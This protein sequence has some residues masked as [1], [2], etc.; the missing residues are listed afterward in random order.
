MQGGLGR[1]GLGRAGSRGMAARQNRGGPI[2]I[3]QGHATPTPPQSPGTTL[4]GR[5]G[6]PEFSLLSAH[7]HRLLWLNSFSKV[8]SKCLPR[9]SWTREGQQD[10]SWQ[11]GPRDASRSMNIQSS[12]SRT[13]TLTHMCTCAPARPQ[14]GKAAA[15]R[16]C[17]SWGGGSVGGGRASGVSG[18]AWIHLDTPSSPCVQPATRAAG[19]K[20]GRGLARSLWCSRRGPEEAGPRG[21]PSA[22]RQA[23]AQRAPAL[24]IYPGCF[25]LLLHPA[26]GSLRTPPSAIAGTGEVDKPGCHMLH[27][28]DCSLWP[29]GMG[30]AAL[31]REPVGIGQSAPRPASWG[32]GREVIASSR[33]GPEHINA[34]LTQG[35]GTEATEGEGRSA[36]AG[37]PGER[38]RRWKQWA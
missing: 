31:N 8:N 30:F 15:S 27:H 18:G 34:S 24:C 25:W 2:L 19:R 33:F 1:Q 4:R 28:P 22:R 21:H 13:D 32:Q 38:G 17:R 3:A 7:R 37:E 12:H 11:R 26:R 5:S 16:Q 10:L 36:A 14:A 35:R 6:H 20:T 9:G 29:G 23:G